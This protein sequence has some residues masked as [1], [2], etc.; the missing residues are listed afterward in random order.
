MR[1]LNSFLLTLSA[2]PRAAREKVYKQRRHEPLNR[3]AHAALGALTR[4]PVTP[5]CFES[6]AVTYGTANKLLDRRG[7]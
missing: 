2:A 1:L 4:G 3:E 7:L 6:I 5:A